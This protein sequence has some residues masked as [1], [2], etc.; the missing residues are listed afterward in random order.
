[1][2][3]EKVQEDF[4]LAHGDN[5]DR[6]FD[7]EESGWSTSRGARSNLRVFSRSRTGLVL[8]ALCGFFLCFVLDRRSLS[9]A[10]AIST[11]V[12]ATST[13]TNATLPALTNGLKTTVLKKPEGLKVVGF[14]FYGRRMFV[15]ILECHLRK[16]LVRNGGYLDEIHFIANTKKEE[17]LEFLDELIRDVP[18]Y[19][20]V[21]LT[22]G[23]W[24]GLWGHS[25]NLD[26]DAILIKIDDD[27][28]S[29]TQT[30][31]IT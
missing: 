6:S 10:T 7:D 5:V 14:L 2:V 23:D 1:M 8:A 25:A 20:R 22:A 18:E 9:S 3:V 15:N 29:T 17:D 28:V 11:V 13:V 24:T 27:V 4:L 30:A 16:N 12:N 26:P 31:S 19:K 21:N